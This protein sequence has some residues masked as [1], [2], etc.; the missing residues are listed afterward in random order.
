MKLDGWLCRHLHPCGLK[1]PL[2]TPFSKANVKFSL[3]TWAIIG[4]T[5]MV[6]GRGCKGWGGADP[7]H[8][9]SGSLPGG[10][11]LACLPTVVVSGPLPT[12]GAQAKAA[13]TA[14]A[15]LANKLPGGQGAA[16][17][18]HCTAL[19]N[20]PKHSV[21]W[22]RLQ[23]CPRHQQWHGVIW[24]CENLPF[25]HHVISPFLRGA[26][27]QSLHPQRAARIARG[28]HRLI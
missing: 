26:K 27:L 13:P 21:V 2:L 5:V 23:N 16:K 25:V 9:P 3:H 8:E 19:C 18:G 7:W 4:S 1:P 12:Q 24:G 17:S 11:A 10:G 15:A 14:V 6:V 22:C 28:F 20:T